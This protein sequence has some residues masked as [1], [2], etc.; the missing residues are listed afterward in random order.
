MAIEIEVSQLMTRVAALERE[1]A[2]LYDHLGV[3]RPEPPGEDSPASER[4]AQLARS[5]D[6]I[7]AIK[8]HRQETGSD[9]RTAKEL[10]ERIAAS[11]STG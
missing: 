8:L 10:V 1:L 4:V 5:G 6:I 2:Y 3:K 9:L 7:R 11:S